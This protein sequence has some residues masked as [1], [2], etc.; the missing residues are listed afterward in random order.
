[1]YLACLPV[2]AVNGKSDV[3]LVFGDYQ[4]LL[5]HKAA[6]QDKDPNALAEYRDLI[7]RA[8]RTLEQKI[9][10]VVQK[11][12]TPPSGDKHDYQSQAPYW[13]P[14]PEKPNGLPYIWRDG[15]V[16]PEARGDFMDEEAKDRFF[17]TVNRLGMAAFYTEDPRYAQR[18]VTWLEAW[19]IDPQTCMNPNLQYAQFV[20]GRNQGRCIGIIEWSGVG[21]LITPIQLLH[22]GGFIPEP[23][24]LG[25][26]KWFEDYLQWLL[27]S[28]NGRQEGTR[29]NNHGT[30]YDVQ[31][32]GILLF[33]DKKDEARKLLEAVK[34]KRI[35][36]QIEPDGRQPRELA[37]TKSLSY[38]KMNLSAFIKLADLGKKVGVDLWGY[39]TE[40]GRSIRKAQAFLEPYLSKK[41]KWPYRQLGLN[42]GTEEPDV[43]N[44]DPSQRIWA[45]ERPRILRKATAYLQ[46][47]PRTV[48]AERCERSQ[49]TPHDFY[50]EGDYWW[51]DPKNPDGPFIR[52]DGETYPGLF[53]AHRQAMVRLSDI[54]GT[55]VSA[56]RLTNDSRYVTQAVTH[57]KAW[58]V[59]PE[60][61]MNPSLLY[62]QAI[63]GRS[64]GRSIGIIDTLH[65]SEVARGVKILSLS[66][67]FTPEDQAA[68][69]LWFR[70]YLT[71]INTHP[72]GLKEK[73]H[74]NNHG[75]CWSMQAAAFA[76]LVGDE[77][78]LAWVR[79]QFKTV[80]LAEM[81]DANGGFPAELGRTKP[82]GYSLFVID[83]MAGVAQIV[84][85][86]QDDL[87]SYALPDGRG[88]RLGMDFIVPYIR[89]KS[90]WPYGH[91]V[92]Y[93]DEWPVRQPC[94]VFAGVAFDRKDYL[95][96][97]EPLEADP[98]TFEVLRNLPLRHPLLWI[99]PK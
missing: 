97:W 53:V 44:D 55:L 22:A 17:S 58:F 15:R 89:D 56:Y 98:E 57:L 14:D 41:K 39:E 84:S 49:G 59:D 63:M 38:S 95:D 21:N 26:R 46:A 16:N 1:M 31:V 75:V 69:K 43:T 71:W 6:M 85:T 34:T 77:E 93:W 74:P 68:V 36:C 4:E 47:E 12:T 45:I 33:L 60:T 40:D 65:L 62:G 94:L 23:T 37:R 52:R 96:L 61:R 3:D 73:V 82:Y 35:A 90:T 78:I 48:T 70:D 7:M 13:W 92:L 32:A 72:Y 28:E 99:E 76:D 88:M 64:T 2:A 9:V 19:F 27:T 66:P 18:V 51:P 5:Q 87:W 50:S 25:I 91:D 10:S 86:P 30:W 29:L 54:I 8:D 81:M 83:A 79:H 24:Y 20:P 80:Y 42:E 11:R 67:V